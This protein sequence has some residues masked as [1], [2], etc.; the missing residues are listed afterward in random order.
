MSSNHVG[1]D[2]L[3][4]L[5]TNTFKESADR[6]GSQR[7]GV[8][9]K[10]KK[11]KRKVRPQKAVKLPMPP[12]VSTEQGGSPVA[13]NPLTFFPSKGDRVTKSFFGVD[14]NKHKRK[15]ESLE[16]W[17]HPE[18]IDP[19]FGLAG[20]S[21]EIY[22]RRSYRRIGSTGLFNPLKKEDASLAQ[23]AES[24]ASGKRNYVLVE[25]NRLAELS[26][27]EGVLRDEKEKLGEQCA[28]IMSDIQQSARVPVPA[29]RLA[30]HNLCEGE[31]RKVGS[32]LVKLQSEWDKYSKDH[33]FNRPPVF[34]KDS[35]AKT[36]PLSQR[37]LKLILF[38]E[39]QVKWWEKKERDRE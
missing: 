37:G 25:E 1:R 17:L 38:K 13:L 32:Q 24:V 9:E 20:D 28:W 23:L 15:A 21:Q 26:K 33:S 10:K 6:E 14:F 35:Y 22:I 29:T 36:G 27:L 30:M 3:L 18:V 19:Q 16:K 2:V 11:G 31:M 4:R 12:P 7:E 39:A 8:G 5:T 34:L